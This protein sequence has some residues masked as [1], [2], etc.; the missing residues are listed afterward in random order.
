MKLMKND[1]SFDKKES[2]SQV[3]SETEHNFKN[4]QLTLLNNYNSFY[5][6]KDKLFYI[7]KNDFSEKSSE[8]LVNEKKISNIQNSTHY[9][10]DQCYSKNQSYQNL[11]ETS[12][13]FVIISKAIPKEGIY[14]DPT[15]HAVKHIIT[16][17]STN[18][19]KWKEYIVL[20]NGGY[21]AKVF[22][23]LFII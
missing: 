3:L 15:E 21:K 14:Y 19:K 12:D 8:Y 10:F 1:V 17:I 11:F 22:N 5:K 20:F 23:K 4:N 16:E 2:F 7:L 6:N 18:S 9:F 13:F